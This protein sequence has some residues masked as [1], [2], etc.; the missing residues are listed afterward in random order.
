M[1]NDAGYESLA[2]QRRR[3]DREHCATLVRKRDYEGYLC[4]LLLPSAASRESYFAIRALNV[5]VAGIKDASGSVTGRTRGVVGGRNGIAAGGG[6]ILPS[7]FAG[8]DNTPFDDRDGNNMGGGGSSMA[9]R[10]RM[11]WWKD[12]IS[13]IYSNAATTS[14]AGDDDL[15]SSAR[16]NPTLRS[17]AHA[18]R[19]HQLT[20]RFIRRLIEARELDLDMTQYTTMSNVAQYGEDTMSNVL[21]LTFECVNVRDEKADLIASDIGVGL[22]ILTSLRSTGFRILQNECSIPVD[23]ATRYG[24]T[25]DMLHAALSVVEK[26][27]DDSTTSTNTVIDADRVLSSQEALRNAVIEMAEL[28]TF[29]LHRAREHQSNVPKEGRMALLPAVCGLHYLNSLKE[30]NYNVLHPSLLG[31]NNDPSL[32]RVERKRRLNL[33]FLLGRTWLTGTF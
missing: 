18:I 13:Q 11:Q 16:R 29:H 17:V 23:V 20:H 33:M 7:R 26:E 15:S 25:M 32:E 27:Q 14:V 8:D 5:E 4:G 24:I 30:C 31:G 12:A 6:A 19:T 1:I 3:D 21:Y 9:R 2:S 22:G 28:A 10:L